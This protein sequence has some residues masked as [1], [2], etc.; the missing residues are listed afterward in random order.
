[1][2]RVKLA[3]NVTANGKEY[4]NNSGKVFFPK[5]RIPSAL[6]NI[7]YTFLPIKISVYTMLYYIL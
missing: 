5:A 3:K 1:M 6:P 7:K 2:V 4:I